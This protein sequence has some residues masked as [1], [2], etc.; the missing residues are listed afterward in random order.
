MGYLD[1]LNDQQCEAVVYLDGPELVIAGAGSGKTRVLTYKIAHL[2]NCGFEPWRILALTFTNKAAN[3]MRERVE[4]IVGTGVSGK[5]WMGTF[6]SIFARILRVNADRLGY[7]SSYTIYDTADSKALVKMIIKDMNLDEKIYKVQTVLSTISSAKNALVSPDEYALDREIQEY[8]RQSRHPLMYEIYRAYNERCFIAGAMDFDDLLFNTYR[9]FR[10]NPD[11]LRHYREYFRY[12]LVD[13]YQDTNYAQHAII[14]QLTSG[15]GN[16]CVVGDDAQSIYSFRGASIGNI[17]NLGKQYPDLKTCKLEQ[18]YRSSQTI[19][20]A[21]NSLISKNEQQIPKNVFSRN[22]IGCPIEVVKTYSDM[23]EASLVASR[24]SRLKMSSE[25]SYEEY[26]VLYRTNAQSRQLEEALRKRNIP[27]RIWGGLSFYQRKEVKDAIAYMRLSVNHDD[28]EALRR[29]INYPTRGIGETTIR[30]LSRCAIDSKHSI[31]NVIGHLDEYEHGIGRAAVG[32]LIAFRNLIVGFTGMNVD[33][34]NDAYTVARRIISDSGIM[35]EFLSERTPEMISRRENISELINGI[36]EFVE[37]RREEG[38]DHLSLS[39]F[40]T[41]ASLSTDQDREESG[42]DS[43]TL[44]T[45]H[46]AKGLEF[47]NVFIVGVEDELFPSSMST[48]SPEGI[49]EERRLLYV[50]MTRAK[51]F[52]MMSYASSRFRNGQVVLTKPSPFL[53]NI[54]S[55]YLS[56][57]DSSDIFTGERMRDPMNR[58]RTSSY[59]SK[60]SFGT[61]RTAADS[62][63]TM[64]KAPIASEKSESARSQIDFDKHTHNQLYVGQS[65]LHERFG[66]GVIQEIDTSQPDSRIIVK[67][68]NDEATKKL[69][70]KFAKFKILD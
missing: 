8:D 14:R 58:Y 3:E 41:Q 61:K 66:R 46:A 70:L 33:A 35:A 69:L 59:Q 24:I 37:T 65:I 18:N 19:I 53:A 38:D 26:A 17:L 67:F 64:V 45:V 12:V 20:N 51:H 5:L 23:E 42:Q 1:Q 21:A 36:R 15:Q 47:S 40:L 9:L 29:I 50:A 34:E 30:K 54:D 32:K 60:P 43:V 48:G 2:I 25:D 63:R 22:E 52:C 10:D 39:D 49:E 57:S 55:K 68:D 16:L 6:H 4:K 27:Y 56:V 28:E 62:S 7:K 11:I 31:W 13:E 44:M